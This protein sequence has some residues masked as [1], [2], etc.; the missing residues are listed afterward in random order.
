MALRQVV[1]GQFQDDRD[2]RQQL[3]HGVLGN[4]AE[5]GKRVSECLRQVRVLPI[6]MLPLESFDL[7]TVLLDDVWLLTFHSGGLINSQQVVW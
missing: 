2:Q 1:F 4:M 3:L 5:M 6:D 7:C